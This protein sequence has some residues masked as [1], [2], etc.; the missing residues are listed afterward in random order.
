MACVIINFRNGRVAVKGDV[1]KCTT[2]FDW[3]KKK[4]PMFDAFFGKILTRLRKLIL[5]KWLLTILASSQPAPL[6]L[7]PSEEF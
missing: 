4:T 6:L 2:V 3:R 7:M 5:T 1:R